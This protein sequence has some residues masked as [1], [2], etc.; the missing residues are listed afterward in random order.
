MSKTANNPAFPV[1]KAPFYLT[2]ARRG[3]YLKVISAQDGTDMLE[4]LTA[5]KSYCMTV[6]EKAK[7][8]RALARDR[9]MLKSTKPGRA[10]LNAVQLAITGKEVAA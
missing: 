4:V 8:D 5:E 7:A 9:D 3:Q 2:L 1:I 6:A 10:F